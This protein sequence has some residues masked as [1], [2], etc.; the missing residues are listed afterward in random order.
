MNGLK[1]RYPFH[2]LS[3]TLTLMIQYHYLNS[4][5][6]GQ[7]GLRMMQNGTHPMP[8]G[9]PGA[10]STSSNPGSTT[11]TPNTTPLKRPATTSTSTSTIGPSAT[12]TQTRGTAPYHIP[13]QIGATRPRMGVFPTPT[14]N[15]PN[16]PGPGGLAG[17]GR[18]GVPVRPGQGPLHQNGLMQ[19]QKPAPAPLPPIQRGRDA[20]LFAAVETMDL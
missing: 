16:R 10:T 5:E 9:V 17:I 14:T 1:V 2:G 18:A 12:Q 7:Y 13:S 20:V 6:H 15:N 4:G 8:T 19:G 3:S 11:S